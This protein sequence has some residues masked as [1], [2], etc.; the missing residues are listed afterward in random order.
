MTDDKT[1]VP[2]PAADEQPAP[3]E[4]P[5]VAAPAGLEL[6]ALRDR[7][8]RLAADFD[9]FRKRALKERTEVWEKA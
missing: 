3:P 5:P 4:S 6:A 2:E 7:H 1:P 8:L 9:N